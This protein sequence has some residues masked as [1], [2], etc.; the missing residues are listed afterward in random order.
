M[1]LE[2]G[3]TDTT[4]GATAP[5]AYHRI[6]RVEVDTKNRKCVIT[7]AVFYRQQAAVDGKATLELRTIEVPTGQ[8][9][10]LF[11]DPLRTRAYTYLKTLASYTG[12]VDVL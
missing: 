12:A 1:A 2:L 7:V 10:A 9:D 3:L 8:F 11:G 5:N 6:V 4:I